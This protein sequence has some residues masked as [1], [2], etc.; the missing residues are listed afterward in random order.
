MNVWEN[1][2]I[3]NKGISLLSKLMAGSNLEIT[4]AETGSGYVTPGL[5][6]AQTDVTNP[7]QELSFRA[8]SYPEEGKCKLPCF[9][10]NDGVST[11]YTAKQVG[12]YA[13]D[14][15]DGEILFFIAQAQSDKGT[16]VPSET[17]MPG[18]S[19][20]WA[21]Y[22]NYGQADA[23]SV[24]VDPSN[25]VTHAEMEQ[26][27]AGALENIESS[28]Q[29]VNA[30]STDGVTY[31]AT[32]DGLDSLYN[33]FSIVMIPSMANTGPT[34]KLNINGWGNISLMRTLSNNASIGLDLGSGYMMTGKPLILVYASGNWIVDRAKPGATDLYGTVPIAS[35]GTGATTAEAART[36]LGAASAEDLNAHTNKKDNPHGVTKAQVGLGNV[37]NVKQVPMSFYNVE[38]TS[39]DGV[40]YTATIDG[41]TALF[42][43][44]T[45]TIIPKKNST[46]TSVTLNLNNLGA[47]SIVYSTTMSSSS[48][49]TPSYTNWLM[50]GSPI[51]IEYTGSRWKTVKAVTNANDFTGILPVEKGGT[52]ATTKEDAMQN[53]GITEHKTDKSNPHGVT[54]TQIGAAPAY[55]Y[56]TSDLTA[57]TSAL[58]TGKLHFVY[59]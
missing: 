46:S 16:E 19:A 12:I 20:E 31:T 42:A 56:G 35:G 5:L 27:V 50:A 52:G 59:E 18:Y 32:I 48:I 45:I 39:S 23:V 1:A 11:G 49:S 3:T 29:V 6:I 33:G 36:N 9:L 37:D 57:G 10:T 13:H 34:P 28:L 17:E 58:E 21:F 44:L 53:L 38:A 24:T 7:M 22:F 51:Q 14:P 25:A 4:R 30:T 43:G 2:V 15:D 40:A 26:Y 41:L 8:T 54:A 55:T 47:K